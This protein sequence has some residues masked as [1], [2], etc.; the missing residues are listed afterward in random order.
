MQSLSN[1]IALSIFIASLLTG[2]GAAMASFV[3]MSNDAEVQA[4]AAIERNM[5][6]AWN[7]L[8]KLGNAFHMENG[9]LYA[10]S[11]PLNDRTDVVDTVSTLVGGTAT[12][13]AA[14]TRIA[15]SVRKDDGSRA[16]GTKLARNEAYDRVLNQKSPFR[17]IIDILG[18]SYI[19]GYDPI[20]DSG[21]SVIGILYVG[22]K[23]DDFFHA[24]TEVRKWVL[25]LTI[26]TSALVVGIA[27][28]FMHQ[29][30]TIPTRNLVALLKDLANSK[31][32]MDVPYKERKD[33]I[34]QIAGAVETWRQNSINRRKLAIEAE[35]EKQAKAERAV[36]FESLTRDFS[37]VIESS[38]SAVSTA[39]NQLEGAST[40]LSTVAEQTSSRAGLVV[41]A[42]EKSAN[43]VQSVAAATEQLSQAISNI[44]V[45]VDESNTVV[46]KA[47][48]QANH[49][50][51]LVRGLAST[52]QKIGDVVNLINDIAGQTNLLALNATIEAARA[53]DAGK[54]FAIVAGEV[55]NLATQTARATQEIAAQVSAVQDATEDAAREIESISTVMDEVTTISSQIA[56]SIGQQQQATGAIASNIAIAAQSSIDITDNISGV[57]QGIQ[58]TG[59]GTRV[60]EDVSHTLSDQAKTIRE[61]VESFINSLRS[62]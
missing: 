56:Q 42:A 50:N 33:E 8:H 59:S 21:G 10:D 3:V 44:A 58:E 62:A 22:I 45:R 51:D 26:L 27:L 24:M 43:T 29:Q 6:V 40:S 11:T 2:L 39:V 5:R 60:V 7:E 54:G 18:T 4:N 55:K 31:I 49:A 52:A 23:T 19:T 34:G 38:V 25:A 20:L 1:K 37:S 61:Q 32:D 57:S 12:I 13:F 47:A 48:Q 41:D 53:G 35:N 17:G 46:V 15:T 9:I 30:I 14:D 16:S 28:R 36:R